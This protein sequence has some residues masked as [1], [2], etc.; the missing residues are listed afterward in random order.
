MGKT[1]HKSKFDEINKQLG[2]RGYTQTMIADELGISKQRVNRV[3]HGKEAGLAI[4]AKV[5]EIIGV[6]PEDIWPEAFVN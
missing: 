4:K 3:I 2:L 5:G 6:A 1:K